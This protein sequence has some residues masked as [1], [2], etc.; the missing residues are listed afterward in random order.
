MFVEFRKN[1]LKH[2]IKFDDLSQMEQEK[3]VEVNQFFCGL[4]YLVKLADQAKA[5][6]KIWEST[7]HKDRKV[8][9]S[10][11]GGYSNGESGVTRLIRTVCKSV[12]ERGC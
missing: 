6:L 10:A 9:S 5:C 8:G 3:M 1:I 11:H 7:I 12:Q 4:N 2:T